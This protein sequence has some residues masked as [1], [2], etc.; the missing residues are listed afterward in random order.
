MSHHPRSRHGP[1]AQRPQHG[2]AAPGR[3]GSPGG[4]RQSPADGEGVANQVERARVRRAH[5]VD[6]PRRRRA[7]QAVALLNL[8]GF[9]SGE[10]RQSLAGPRQAAQGDVV[11]ER[12]QHVASFH[13][14]ASRLQPAEAVE[15]PAAAVMDGRAR[16][17]HDEGVAGADERQC[18]GQSFPQPV[19][20]ALAR[21]PGRQLGVGGQ[22]RQP[23]GVQEPR[24]RVLVAGPGPARL[25]QA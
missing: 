22:G 23:G 10:A 20:G 19:G 16:Q 13:E 3:T 8:G 9:Q 5:E 14:R 4:H 1:G 15:H 2:R 18:L 25:T 21:L 6:H 7:R 12:E 17:A 11:G 24:A